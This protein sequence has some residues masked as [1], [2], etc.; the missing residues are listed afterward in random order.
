MFCG[1]ERDW[2]ERAV[3]TMKGHVGLMGHFSIHRYW[4]EGGLGADFTEE[5]YDAVI[6]EAHRT[7]EFVQ[8]TRAM[9]DRIDPDRKI[10]IALDEWGMWQGDARPW[11][12]SGTE[13]YGGD[14]TQAGTL[15]D[16]LAAAVALEGFHRQC[17]VLSLCNLAQVANVPHAPVMTDGMA[18]W[19]TPT[20]HVLRMH[21]PHIGAEAL[22]GTV[23]EDSK[24]SAT[25]TR[26]DGRLTVSITNR[27]YR[28]T[29]PVHLSGL[30]G[31]A[32]TELL[33]AP[34]EAQNSASE[35][36]RVAPKPLEVKAD[37]DGVWLPLPPHSFAT[38]TVG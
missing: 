29:N 18:F 32:T 4:L 2:N 30:S 38:V 33:H 11:S 7:E 3:E 17:N 22:P 35:P 26:K 37:A 13:G 31:P 16:A 20:Y 27:S 25:A 23:E 34:A 15:R 12:P 28:D 9:L 24:V 6:A 14:Y 36:N 21:A 10:G 8:E 19:A 5:R 1:Q